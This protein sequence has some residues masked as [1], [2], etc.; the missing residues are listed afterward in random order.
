[1]RC[2]S[3]LACTGLAEKPVKLLRQR[4]ARAPIGHSRAAAFRSTWAAHSISDAIAVL[5]RVPPQ[6]KSEPWAK[7][8]SEIFGQAAGDAKRRFIEENWDFI[9][10]LDGR[11]ASRLMS[12]RRDTLTF[13]PGS[14]GSPRKWFVGY[15]KM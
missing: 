10:T 14:T 12:K 7:K 4:R 15:G 1:M 3:N 13:R 6:A 9:E 5:D 11:E 2:A 8:L